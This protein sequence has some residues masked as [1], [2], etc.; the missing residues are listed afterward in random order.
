VLKFS[1]SSGDFGGRT[2]VGCEVTVRL[3]SSAGI[4][5]ID[6]AGEIDVYSVSRL[7]TALVNA[8][9]EAPSEIILDIRKVRYIDSTGLGVLIGGLRRIREHGGSIKIV[10]IDVHIRKILEITGM[11]GIFALYETESEAV[12]NK[13][14]RLRSF[15]ATGLQ[16]PLPTCEST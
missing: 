8:L 2:S 15:R 14:A 5:I 10:V 12:Q 3:A 1:R 9:S 6:V 7:K 16:E 11:S 13:P 4:Q